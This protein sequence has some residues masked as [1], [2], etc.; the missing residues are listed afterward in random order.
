VTPTEKANAAFDTYCALDAPHT[1]YGPH[2]LSVTQV[3]LSRWQIRNFGS[4]SDECIALGAAEE[5]GELA[6]AVLKHVQKIRG[7]GNKE[8]Y[9]A[10]AGDAIADTVVYLVQL[11]TSLRLDFGTLFEETA[12][13]VMM[14]DWK[15]NKETGGEG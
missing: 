5:V 9:R 1:P 15:A 10:A 8:A 4:Q 6:H 7:M 12:R 11:C 14:R 2:P 13:Q 3:Q